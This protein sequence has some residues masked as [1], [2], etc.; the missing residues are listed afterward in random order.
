MQALNRIQV[1]KKTMY[2]WSVFLLL[3]LY[4]QFLIYFFVWSTHKQYAV[5]SEDLNMY[6]HVLNKQIMLNV[7][8]DSLYMQMSDLATDRVNNQL[9]LEKYIAD[10]KNEIN[11]LIGKDSVNHFAVYARITKNLNTMLFL[12]DSIV[13]VTDQEIF[14]KNDLLRCI[15]GNSKIQSS[16]FSKSRIF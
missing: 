3:V 8:M 16:I 15:E 12:K 11:N 9:F 2:F 1:R 5:V 10:Q 13:K 14:I 7:K 4:T 6:K